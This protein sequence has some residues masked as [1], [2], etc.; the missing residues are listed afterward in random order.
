MRMTLRPWLPG[1]CALTDHCGTGGQPRT[2]SRDSRVGGP[3]EPH[4]KIR[5][6][7]E[8]DCAVQL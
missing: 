5:T 3:S 7:Y 2:R 1:L 4:Q 6:M 8:R